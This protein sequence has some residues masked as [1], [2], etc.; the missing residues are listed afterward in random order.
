VA[1]YWAR[2]IR[3]ESGRVRQACQCWRELWGVY[4][5]GGYVLMGCAY[6]GRVR[7]GPGDW[8]ALPGEV[9]DQLRRLPSGVLSHGYCEDC[10]RRHFPTHAQTA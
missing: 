6:C 10:L 1:V 3:G 2:E 4:R 9:G 8:M 5:R 7:V